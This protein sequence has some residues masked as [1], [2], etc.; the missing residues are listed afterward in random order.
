MM[1]Q[2]CICR[3]VGDS[4][5]PRNFKRKVYIAFGKSIVSNVGRGPGIYFILDII[6]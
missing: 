4:I 6:N 3:F 1:G 2:Q 5:S